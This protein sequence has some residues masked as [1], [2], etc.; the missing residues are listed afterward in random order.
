MRIEAHGLEHFYGHEKVLNGVDITINSGSFTAII[1]ESGS[2]KTTLLSILSTL[3]QPTKGMTLYD[4]KTLGEWGNIDHFRRANIGFVFQFH[5]LISYLTLRENIALG[6][7]DEGRIELL[8]QSLGIAKLSHRYSDEV[9]GGERQRAAIARALVNAPA[10]VF[11]DEPT[12][13]LDSKNA[14]G[15]YELFREFSGTGTGFVVASHD[16]KIVDYADTIIEMEDGIVK[17]I[18]R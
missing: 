17:Q 2:G 16:K 8:L 5:Y 13:N 3:L 15:V 6:A 12:G 7:I 11:A 10:V 9:S 1:G 14:L 4:G 18:H